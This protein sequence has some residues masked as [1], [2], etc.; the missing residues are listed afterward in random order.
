MMPDG[1]RGGPT[2]GDGRA[3]QAPVADVLPNA[4]RF[5]DLRPS[6]GWTA[7]R[8]LMS[9]VRNGATGQAAE[10]PESSVAGI[11]GR[12]SAVQPNGCDARRRA[13][14]PSQGRL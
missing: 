5:K 1:G 10:L 7:P 2:A 8:R 3:G 13:G 6:R 11:L 14:S 4:S 12:R 9:D